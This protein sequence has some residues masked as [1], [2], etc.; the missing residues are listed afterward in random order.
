MPVPSRDRT[1]LLGKATKHIPP[2]AKPS[3]RTCTVEMCAISISQWLSPSRI[4]HLPKQKGSNYMTE[5]HSP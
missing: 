1:F 4:K 5:A 3:V 2:G